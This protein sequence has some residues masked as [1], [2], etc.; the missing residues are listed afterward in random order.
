MADTP[1][2]MG[3]EGRIYR[4][5]AG[6]TAS[7]EMLSATDVS[8]SI[9]PKKATTMTRGAGTAPPMETER[10]VSIGL[11]IEWTLLNK[12]GETHLDTLRAAAAAGTPVALRLKDYANGKGFDGDVTLEVKEGMPLGGEA[13]YQF[14]ATPTNE[15][16]REPQ[17]Y[18]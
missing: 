3:F 2:R 17:A 7:T 12:S 10:V 1:T 15:K 14:T 13:S 6:T 4:G 9:T 16:G 5:T 18:V 8:T 11:S